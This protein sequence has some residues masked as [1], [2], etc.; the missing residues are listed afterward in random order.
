MINP[1]ELRIGNLASFK[2]MWNAE[3]S[4]I[5]SSGLICFKDISGGFDIDSI[6]PIALTDEILVKSG[7]TFIETPV[8]F[9]VAIEDYRKDQF[10]LNFTNYLSI[11]I[12]FNAIKGCDISNRCYISTIKYVHQLQN[13]YFALIGQELAI[14]L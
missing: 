14:N 5:H 12:E 7:F 2:G 11:Q 4:D 8:G 3:L 9:G 13:I 10:V 6:M 1:N